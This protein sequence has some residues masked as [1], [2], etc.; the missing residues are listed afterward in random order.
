Q[1]GKL[2]DFD[3]FN[4][5]PGDTMSASKMSGWSS[6]QAGDEATPSLPW[7]VGAVSRETPLGFLGVTL[8]PLMIV[9]DAVFDGLS[10]RMLQLGPIAPEHMAVKSDAPDAAVEAIELLYKATAGG[11]IS[12]YSLKE[13]NRSQYLQTMLMN[14]FFYGFLTLITLIGVTNIVNTLD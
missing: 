2:Y 3:L 1:G 12:Y 9:S 8:V 14:L 4:L 6:P 7:T 11:N 10:D 13:H 5:K